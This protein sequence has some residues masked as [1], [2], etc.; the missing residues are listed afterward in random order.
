MVANDIQMRYVHAKFD[1]SE[2]SEFEECAEKLEG[3]PNEYK[4]YSKFKAKI[5][6]YKEELQ[7]AISLEKKF[8]KKYD[9]LNDPYKEG[10]VDEYLEIANEWKEEIDKE[11][12]ATSEDSYEANLKSY[13]ND[14]FLSTLSP[15]L[16]ATLDSSKLGDGEN[17]YADL[18][19]EQ[20]EREQENTETFT[21]SGSEGG[22]PEDVVIYNPCGGAV[23]V[24][25]SI[26]EVET[27]KQYLTLY[28][29][30]GDGKR[31]TILFPREDL[32]E[33][34]IVSLTAYGVQVSKKTADYLIKSIENQEVNVKHLLCHA[35]LGMAEWNGEKIFKGAKG[36]G[37][38]S[39][40]TGKLRVSPKGT[41]ANYKKMLKQDVIGHTPMEFLLS[42]S[43]SGLLVDYL[44]E[45]ISV[46]NIM[47][48][49]IG[50]SST[51][52]TTGA[53]LAVSCGSAPDFL[54]NN[55]VF[56]FQDTLNSLMRLIP[57]S[58]PTLI[59]EGS[60]LTDRDMTQTL[61][62]LSSGTEK[63]RLSGGMEVNE[64]SRF[65]TALFLT[66]EKSILAQC[67]MN[68][69]LLTRNFEFQ[70]VTWTSSAE[71]ADRIKSVVTENYGHIIP[72]VAKWLLEQDRQELVEKIVQ[73]TN[74]V[75]KR[76]REAKTYN[77]LTERTAKQSAL[78][79][80]AVDIVNEVLKLKLN[81]EAIGDFMEEHSLVNSVEQVSI[82]KRAMEWLL[83]FISKN[84][85]Q[86]LSK[87]SPKE[88]SNC[89]GKLENM[90][91]VLLN[92]DEESGMRLKVTASEFMKILKEGHFSEKATVLKE[93]KEMGYLKA[94]SDRYISRIKIVG[95]IQV[96]GYII[97]LPV[98]SNKI[99]GDGEKDY[100]E[101][102]E[103]RR[104]RIN[105]PRQ[106]I[107]DEYVE[108]DFFSI[109]DDDDLDFPEDWK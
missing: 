35:K 86:F 103:E 7:K 81:K 63:R 61:Y 96:K 22:K 24:K 53:L 108:D 25:N 30:S 57:N 3:I 9:K 68:T 21:P 88:I 52:K 18:Q 40:Y 84:Y 106:V 66:S 23:F 39:K 48:H 36:V 90:Q 80:V 34:K 58:Y 98:P 29:D 104:K 95:D 82:G 75:I 50:E 11:F 92:T 100:E 20:E 107:K 54:G 33:N 51:G 67:N 1:D 2:D 97:Q 89:R 77:N 76:A 78:I 83:Q 47:V 31:R 73:E 65:R 37:I 12:P 28:F 93:W 41:Y 46:E 19:K 99:G 49:M 27:C 14:I 5:K 105:K 102:L 10:K 70:N 32:V 13:L 85:T 60:L 87:D 26:T 62:S 94:Q 42:A 15:Y 6:L 4:K 74:A 8:R 64:S 45:S 56:S 91:T 43:I 44:K 72:R 16:T 101:V 38:D 17:P 59:D 79:L 109:D 69:G 55:F 71:S